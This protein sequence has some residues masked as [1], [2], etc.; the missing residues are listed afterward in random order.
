VQEE[1]HGLLSGALGVNKGSVEDLENLNWMWALHATGGFD[2]KTALE[3]MNSPHEYIRAWAIQ[4]ICER[5]EPGADV[6][7]RFAEMA[8]KDPSPV[9][10]LY[11]ASAMQRVAPER[12]W[13]T[14]T[15]LLQHAEDAAD[16]NLP[17]MYWYATEGAVG[18]DPKRGAQLL[19][20]SKIPLVR[21]YI[22]RRIASTSK[23]FAVR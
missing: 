1:V 4:L 17:L 23:A 19:A 12:R 5:G 13:D 15:A 3:Q 21:Q 8:A 7:A 2:E 9:V 10:R 20:Q 16:H 18:A 11:L 6:L 14:L 22:A